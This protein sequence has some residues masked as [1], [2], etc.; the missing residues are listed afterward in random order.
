MHQE[1]NNDLNYGPQSPAKLSFYAFVFIPWFFMLLSVCP[2][3]QRLTGSIRGKMEYFVVFWASMI[4]C[5]PKDNQ[6]A[7]MSPKLYY[8]TKNVKVV[9]LIKNQFTLSACFCQHTC[10]SAYV[11]GGACVRGGFF[12]ISVLKRVCFPLLSLTHAILFLPAA[13]HCRHLCPTFCN[14]MKYTV[15]L[16]ALSGSRHI[17]ITPPPKHDICSCDAKDVSSR[18]TK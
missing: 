10:V 14:L 8:F 11:R 4:E 15:C 17:F 13:N 16:S 2:K 3:D 5:H 18:N 7:A 12:F 6:G 9:F 1:D